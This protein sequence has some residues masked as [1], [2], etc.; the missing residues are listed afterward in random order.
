VVLMEGLGELL[1]GDAPRILVGVTVAVPPHACSASE[2]VGGDLH[3]LLVSAS[4]EV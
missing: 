1:P 4:G 3:T 2:L